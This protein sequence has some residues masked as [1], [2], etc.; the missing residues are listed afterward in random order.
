MA[1]LPDTLEEW[2]EKAKLFQCHK[3]RIDELHKGG[4][5]NSFW[6]QPSPA[7]R[8]TQDPDAMEMD[9]VKLKKLSPQEWAKC[10]RK[11]CCFK[12]RKVGH[13]AKNC[14][15]NSWSQ[16]AS[17]PSCPSQQ[18]LTTEEP[19]A[20]YILGKLEDKILQTLKLCYEE[21]NEEIKVIETFNDL[22]DF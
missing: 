9:F 19:P 20:T 10:M 2:I 3:L 11:G 7:T 22:E 8:A 13:N 12:C 17:G 16:P 14:R 1:S 4:R 15:T 6:P 5:Y 18:I 21:S